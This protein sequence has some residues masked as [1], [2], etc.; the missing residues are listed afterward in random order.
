MPKIELPGTPNMVERID[1]KLAIAFGTIILALMLIAVGF[2]SQLFIGLNRQEEDRLAASIAQILDQSIN[3]VAFSG[4]YHTR[5]LVEEMKDTVPDLSYI[6]VESED[7]TIIANSDPDKNGLVV[8]KSQRIPISTSGEPIV[9]ERSFEGGTVKEVVIPYRG[10][11]GSRALG[12]IRIGLNVEAARQT[13]RRNLLGVLV[14]TIILTSS[15]IWAV[16]LLSRRFG[17]TVRNLA[18]QL[19]GIADSL[20]GVIYRFYL[21][22]DGSIRTVF[23]S[24]AAL[25]LFGLDSGRPEDF[26]DVFIAGLDTEDRERFHDSVRAAVKAQASWD[27]T[28]RFSRLDGQKVWFHCIAQVSPLDDGSCELSGV[29]LDITERK[30]AEEELSQS[31]NML[32]QVL[33]TIPQSVFWKDKESRYLGCNAQFA[34]AIGLDSPSEIVSKTDFDLPWPKDEAEAYRRDDRFVIATNGAKHHI[35]EPLQQ[36]DGSRLWIDTSKIPMVDG[37]G[38][39]YGVLGIYDDITEQKRAQEELIESEKRWQFALEGAGDGVYDW[40]IVN[41]K[42]FYSSRV[43]SMLGYEDDDWT[44]DPME[45]ES[46]L[47]PDEQQRVE[48]EITAFI[49]GRISTFNC[50]YRLRCKDGSYKW[51]LD[52]GMILS[53]DDEGKPTRVIGTHADI[54]QQVEYEEQIKRLNI[55][56]ERRVEERTHEL[57]EAMNELESFAYS[58]SHDLRAPLRAIDGYTH[59][60]MEDHRSTIEG[61]A[62]Q[63]LG[64]ISANARKMGQLIDDLLAFSRVGRAE[65]KKEKINLTEL[66]QDVCHDLLPGH[67]F[68]HYTVDIEPDMAIVGDVVLIRQVVQNL[69]ANAIKFSSLK[70]KPTISVKLEP[71]GG[72][73]RCTV[74][75]NGAGFSMDYEDKMFGVFQRLHSATE[76]EGTG[77]G[78]AIVKRIVERHGGRIW[79]QGEEGV[80]ASF[81]FALPN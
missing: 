71:H 64:R 50:E 75:D 63:L 4:K 10:E 23:A 45:G 66:C 53:R 37:A 76:F 52:R 5:L 1:R 47:H 33:N 16:L 62:G 41:N 39:V 38:Q 79:A 9:S 24:Q 43:K 48:S 28:A 42:V 32:N 21:M 58:I 80:G 25:H 2:A 36:A 65:I 6:S 18:V 17:G 61:E 26:L 49:E 55:D 7:G 77:V 30:Q 72:E 60:L 8:P 69:L 12:N 54:S 51:I 11:M 67:T 13:H 35:I 40:D 31:R 74:S 22:P 15:A 68:E 27:F 59:I 3:K 70:D 81:T 44:D 73:S 78:L 57:A 56:L 20:P 19:Q 46:R 29:L 14:L 34:F